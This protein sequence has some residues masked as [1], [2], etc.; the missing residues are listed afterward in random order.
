LREERG[1]KIFE[2]KVL[3][4]TFGLKREGDGSW[5][6]LHND[7]HHNLYSSPNIVKEIKPKRMRWEGHVTHMGILVG[8]T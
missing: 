1:L 4:N 2:N 3:R 7:E 8:R 6:I 5:E